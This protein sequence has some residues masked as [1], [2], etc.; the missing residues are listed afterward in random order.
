MP[1]ARQRQWAGMLVMLLIA[2]PNYLTRNRLKEKGFFFSSQ[3]EGIPPT[4]A[5]K[6][7]HL[8]G[9]AAGHIGSAGR[10]PRTNR[11]W[12]LTIKPQWFTTLH[13]HHQSGTRYSI[14]QMYGEHTNHNTRG[15]G[16]VWTEHEAGEGQARCSAPG[17]CP[18]YDV[19]WKP[20]LAASLNNPFSKS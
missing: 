13:Q 3:F 15:L 10:K 2:G 6:Y 7:W 19:L 8:E 18:I 20:L 11:K 4:V 12:G 14:T 16:S 9:E 1:E 5:G 17:F